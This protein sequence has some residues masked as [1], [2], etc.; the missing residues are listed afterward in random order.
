M[1]W[2]SRLTLLFLHHWTWCRC[3]DWLPQ[4]I[5][6]FPCHHKLDRCSGLSWWQLLS[7]GLFCSPCSGTVEEVTGWWV[8]CPASCVIAFASWLP[9][10]ESSWPLLLEV[11]HYA[12]ASRWTLRCWLQ[13]FDPSSWSASLQSTSL[14]SY[15]AHASSACLEHYEIVESL[16]EFQI[17]NIQC[18]TLIH[19]ASHLFIDSYQ[20]CQARFPLCKS[21]LTIPSH[22]L[23]FSMSGNSFQNYFSIAFPGIQVRPASL[24]FPTFSFLSF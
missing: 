19:W 16:T 8:S 24:Y 5:S 14:S 10:I 1:A 12:P 22:L 6:D 23:A 18:S 2:I 11:C 9:V 21:M 20:F 17:N 3:V 4:L 7:S 13:L 15:L